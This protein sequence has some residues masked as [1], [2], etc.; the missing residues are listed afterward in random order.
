MFFFLIMFNFFVGTYLLLILT[1][2]TVLVQA[3]LMDMFFSKT[4][5]SKLT[6]YRIAIFEHQDV[7]VVECALR[8]L[9]DLC[10]KEFIYNTTSNRCIGL[11]FPD[12]DSTSNLNAIQIYKDMVIYRKGK[13]YF[14]FLSFVID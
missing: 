10:C 12:F 11:H 7:S 9:Q 2:Q 5:L 1:V 3:Q 13:Q 8:S 14:I 4:N 6:D